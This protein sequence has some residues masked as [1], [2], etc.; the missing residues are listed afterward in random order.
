MPH[1]GELLHGVMFQQ[2]RGQ[3]LTSDDLGT[4]LSFLHG[5]HLGALHSSACRDDPLRL[6]R[7]KPWAEERYFNS[8][9][10]LFLPKGD[11]GPLRQV[12]G[13][14]HEQLRSRVS[15][16]ET[17]P[18]HLDLGYS[19]FHRHGDTLE[20]FDFDNCAR[21][22]FLL[23]IAAALYGSIFTVLRCQFV[24]DRSVFEPP[25]THQALEQI[26]KPFWEGYQR[27]N[28]HFEFDP[29]ALSL[30]LEVMYFRSVVHACRMQYGSNS[31]KVQELLLADIHHLLNRTPP[32]DSSSASHDRPATVVSRLRN[33]E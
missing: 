13:D 31:A 19:N 8:D 21:G 16:S 29:E 5:L 15:G 7:R 6:S 30:S 11:Q 33:G 14:L 25:K 24:G 22:P 23:D 17:G 32:C 2:A 18:I 1:E 27:G 9:I 10:D 3:A 28:D 4:E 20:M 26:W 12:F